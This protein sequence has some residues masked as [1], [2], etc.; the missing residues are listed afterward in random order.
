MHA[1]FT[2]RKKQ[3]YLGNTTGTIRI[4]T[5]KSVFVLIKYIFYTNF[6][7][8]SDNTKLTSEDQITGLRLICFTCRKFEKMNLKEM[9]N[10]SLLSAVRF[11]ANL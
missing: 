5:Q 1:K 6:I 4:F 8:N 11:Y 7:L 2:R 10:T 3:S 9:F